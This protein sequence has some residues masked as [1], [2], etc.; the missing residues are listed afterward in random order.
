MAS[1]TKTPTGWRVQFMHKGIRHSTTVRTKA[2]GNA[3]EAAIIHE[4]ESPSANKTLGDLLDR[5][6][7]D[8]SP[9]KRGQRWEL[10]RIEKLKRDKLCKVKLADLNATH[11]ADW[12]DRMLKEV[13]AA[14][15][16]R[17]WNLI[18]PAINIAIKEWR[19][20]PRNPMKDVRRPK[21]AR[22][23]DRLP[24]QDEIDRLMLACGYEYDAP[25]ATSQARVGAAFL[26]AIETGMRSG[27]ILSLTPKTV[28][29]DNRVA[30]LGKT[31]NGDARQV[32]L[33]TEAVRILKQVKCNF[34][35]SADSRDALFRKAKER[36][37]IDDMTFHDSRHLA[38]TRLSKKLE[39]LE[40]A[41]MVGIRDLKI[42]MV[43]YNESAASIAKRLD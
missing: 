2:A 34:D 5:Y 27:E 16:R 29:L 33:S 11:F 32:P 38:I 8:V 36:A 13:S 18:N 20:L 22:S 3:W 41:R 25:P 21:P 39:V 43:Y 6:G 17:E 10:I 12:R 30:K 26:F 4:D 1:Y 35:L 42:L 28:D 40:L 24:T 23:R 9:T 37:Q 19:W 15:V 14:S 31:K 7:R